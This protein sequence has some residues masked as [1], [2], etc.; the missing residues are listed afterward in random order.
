MGRACK[1]VCRLCQAN[2]QLNYVEHELHFLVEYPTY[3]DA[4]MELRRKLQGDGLVLDKM[5]TESKLKL[6]LAFPNRLRYIMEFIR[7]A[8]R[9]RR[10]ALQA[11]DSLTEFRASRSTDGKKEIINS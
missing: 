3:E 4:R 10:E 1:R 8:R 9:A 7:K 11:L 6:L 2:F 5:N